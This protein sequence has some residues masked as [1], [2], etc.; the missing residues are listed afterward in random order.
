MCF[1]LWALEHSPEW[2]DRT[3]RYLTR[4]R[5][6]S[7]VLCVFPIKDYGEFCWY[8]IPPNGL[9]RRFSLVLCDGP[10]GGT[11][12][13]RYGLVPL[14]RERF[15]PGCVILLDDAEREQERAIAHRWQDQM[16]CDLE[17]VGTVK[18]FIEMTVRVPES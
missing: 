1:D 3:Q 6:K 10:P 14:L 15:E 5:L 8:D 16:R 18:P 7:V 13:G 12:G 2:A 4:Y 17:F 11:K 9:P